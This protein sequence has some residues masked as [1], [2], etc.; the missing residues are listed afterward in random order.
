MPTLADFLETLGAASLTAFWLPLALWTLCALPLYL[1]LRM[2]DRAHPLVPYHAGQ[3][4]LFALP[5]G[6]FLVSVADL[7]WLFRPSPTSGP[8]VPF[9]IVLPEIAPQEAEAGVAWSGYHLLGALA[10][11][12]TSLALWRLGRL[13]W[14]GLALQRLRRAL[15]PAGS[16]VQ[17]TL[18]RLARQHRIGRPVAALV[19]EAPLVPMTFGWRR[20]AIV[21][22]AHL[23]SDAEVLR[24]AFA[25]ELAHIRRGDFLLQ[26]AEQVIGAVFFVHPLVAALRRSIVGWRERCCD[27]EVVAR[28]EVSRKR[29][30]ALLL[31]LADVPPPPN[32]FALSMAD[33][34]SNLKT[35]I[36]AMNRLASYSRNPKWIGLGLGAF[37]LGTATLIVACSDVI[38]TDD[39]VSS[40]SAFSLF[41]RTDVGRRLRGR[42]GDARVAA[43]YPRG[44]ML[45]LGECLRYPEIAKKAGIEGRVFVQFVVD[46]NGGVLEPVVQARPRRG[47]GC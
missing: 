1:A 36:L 8:V 3:A 22:P 45:T 23:T 41:K 4:L 34:P 39:S 20:P 40:V 16:D 7:A 31:G 19:A 33:V 28:P 26:W 9:V 13:A 18:D 30:A 43:E 17:A 11:L 5:L 27:A 12:A 47:A 44:S 24:L 35:R 46:E 25:H 2:G 32:R 42:R 14:Q 29:Y 15:A 21:V 10:V 6:L 37:L 38:G